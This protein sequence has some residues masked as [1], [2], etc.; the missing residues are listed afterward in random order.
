M[1][2]RTRNLSNRSLYEGL[3]TNAND[4][5]KATAMTL[6]RNV[7][8]R[9]AGSFGDPLSHRLRRLNN[10]SSAETLMGTQRN[11]ETSTDQRVPVSILKPIQR[12]KLDLAQQNQRFSKQST[13]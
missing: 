9:N 10:H 4:K 8:V 2:R 7:G 5:V 1:A 3:S 11:R 12:M 6:Q 13:E